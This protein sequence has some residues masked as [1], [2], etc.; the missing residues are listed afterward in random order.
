MKH[1]LPSS[2]KH[3]PEYYIDIDALGEILDNLRGVRRH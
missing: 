2:K 1:K 3:D